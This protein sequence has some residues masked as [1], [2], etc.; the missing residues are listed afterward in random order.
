MVQTFGDFLEVEEH[1]EYL[2]I[3]FSP[4]SLPLQQRWRNNGLSANFLAD[5]VV[6]F[7]PAHDVS[8]SNRQLA[9]KDMVA[10]IANELLEN[11]MKYSHESANHPVNIGLHLSQNELRFYVTNQVSPVGLETFQQF[12]RKLLSTDPHELYLQQIE[13]NAT[14]EAAPT[15]HL[16][17]LTML[18]DY[19]AELAWKFETVMT[20]PEQIC[21][22]T[23]VRLIIQEEV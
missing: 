23:M 6:P 4:S 15:S 21:V 18:T 8:S 7:F 1:Q 20:N 16:G 13:A 17:F 5:Y 19:G 11:A 12:I 2:V 22:T 14:N 10:Y 3:G 9:I